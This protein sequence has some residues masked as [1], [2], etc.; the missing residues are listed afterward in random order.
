LNKESSALQG[1][2]QATPVPNGPPRLPFV[3]GV[4]ITGHRVDALAPDVL[5]ALPERIG[6]ALRSVVDSARALHAANQGLFA[7]IPPRFDFISPLAAGADQIAAEVAL[8]LGFRL[9]AVLPFQTAEYRRD[10]AGPAA[11]AMFDDLLA[12]SETRL[13]LPGDRSNEPE[14]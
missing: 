2:A 14:A 7:P 4:G 6:S 1:V 5:A 8:Q 10:M 9:R 13:E 3:L 12:R 11:E